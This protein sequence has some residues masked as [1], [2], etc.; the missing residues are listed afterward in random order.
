MLDRIGEIALWLLLAAGVALLAEELA[1]GPETLAALIWTG[2]AV[3]ALAQVLLLRWLRRE[4]LR[5]EHRHGDL[6]GHG[7]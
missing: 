3:G 4:R 7:D 2:V 1:T 6:A 5:A